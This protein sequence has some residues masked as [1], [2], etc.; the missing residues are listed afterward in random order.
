ME[1]AHLDVGASAAL[2]CEAVGSGVWVEVDATGRHWSR[3]WAD[4]HL[5]V[6]ARYPVGTV[7]QLHGGTV[8]ERVSVVV[9]GGDES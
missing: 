5:A 1:I 9:P 7:L 4:E 6:A 2:L 8:H 3:A